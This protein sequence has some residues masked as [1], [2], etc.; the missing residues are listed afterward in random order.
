MKEGNRC[1]AMCWCK[2]I[3]HIICCPKDC[4]E[5]LKSPKNMLLAVQYLYFNSILACT[6]HCVKQLCILHF[7]FFF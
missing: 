3:F 5:S 6:G 1:I 7:F 4:F 2:V